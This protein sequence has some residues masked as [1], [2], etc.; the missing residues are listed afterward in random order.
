METQLPFG[1]FIFLITFL[2]YLFVAGI[3]FLGFYYLFK[4]SKYFPKIQARFPKLKD[5]VREIG[6]S[7]SSCIIFGIVGW[8]AYKTPFYQH[9]LAY[10]NISDKPMW[11]FWTSIVLLILL[12]DA[13]F[14]WTHR[15]IH[16]KVLFKYF[17]AIHHQSHNPSPWASFSFDPLEALLNACFQLVFMLIIPTHFYAVGVFYFISMVVNVYGH[18]GYEIYPKSIRNHWVG[19]WINTSTSHNYHHHFGKGNYGF[20]FTFWDKFMGTERV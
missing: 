19:R 17:H 16:H 3:A 10:E 1:I 12:H 5:Y 11:Y 2:R 18:L 13:Y 6:Y 20:Y 15:L 14:Y 7:F 8:I 4:N 9:S